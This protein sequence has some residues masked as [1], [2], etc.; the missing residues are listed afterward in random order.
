M[1]QKMIQYTGTKTI[2]ACPMTLGEAEK[3][4]GRH[5]DTSAVEK[6]EETPGYLVEY[7][8][9]GDNYRSWSPK[10]VFEKAYRVSE[11][12][13]DRMYIE[14]DELKSRY[15][16]GKEFTFTQQF[17]KLDMYQQKLLMEQLEAMERYL[18][19]LSRR[20]GAAE[21]AEKLKHENSGTVP[22]A[23]CDTALGG[24]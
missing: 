21:A 24:E 5:I 4:L 17:Q 20:I 23:D 8:E 14:K 22:P 7:G 10:D 2:K 12:F 9:D 18:Y 19:T 3:E 1:K 6:R 15:L 11:T 16:K 13:I